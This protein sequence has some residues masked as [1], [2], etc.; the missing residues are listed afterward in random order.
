MDKFNIAE[1]ITIVK[2]GLVSCSGQGPAGIFLL[3]QIGNLLTPTIDFDDTKISR[4]CKH[5]T[6]VPSEIIAAVSNPTFVS[7]V[8]SGF[9][10]NVARDFNSKTIDNVCLRLHNLINN[11]PNLASSYKTVLN[12]AYRTNDN[13]TFLALALVHAVGMTNTNDSRTSTSVEVPFLT[14]S[15]NHCPMCGNGLFKRVRGRD[16]VNYEIAKIYDDTFDD[17]TKKELE[18]IYPAPSLIDSVENRIILCL[19]CFSDYRIDPTKEKYSRLYNKKRYF[20]LNREISNELNDIDVESELY[21]IIRDLGEL[22]TAHESGLASLDPKEIIEKIPDDV[23]LK[24]DV[25]R[26]V[27]KY[28]RYIEHQ[29]SNLD[30]TGI[31][32]FSIIA[33]QVGEAFET[34]NAMGKLSQKEIFNR[35]AMWMADQL[36]YPIDKISVVNIMI[37]F[38]VQNCEVF[39][40]IS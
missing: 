33:H 16:V 27:L 19:S 23:L 24:D 7:R 31:S 6:E 18:A 4:L 35:L 2:K 40:E 11:E 37:A 34:L 15:N 21:N 17:V 36:G 13:A 29:F 22:S 1:Y 28:Y 32:R 30:A 20:E 5:V 3:E 8:V 38:F 39:H 10:T 25:T 9:S 12:D 14:E 26:W